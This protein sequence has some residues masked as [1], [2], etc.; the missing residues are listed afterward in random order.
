M[1][2][3]NT[4][5]T[6]AKLLDLALTV[7]K[8]AYV[9]YSKFPVGASIESN[10][11]NFYA[12]CN[13]ENVSYP[14]GTCAEAG[15]VAA[16]VAGG[17]KLIRKILIVADSKE[18]IAPC[19]ACLQRI[20][21]FSDDKTRILLASPDGIKKTFKLSQLLPFGFDNTELKND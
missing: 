5:A 3:M 14:I 17:D 7:R 18:L 11:G 8:K 10:T 4:S 1:Q 19:G 2:E 21:E 15:A 20:K 16:M 12:G 6:E 13:V 9:P